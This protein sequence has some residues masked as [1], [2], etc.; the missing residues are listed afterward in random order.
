[1]EINTKNTANYKQLTINT[2]TAS[3]NKNDSY[4]KRTVRT[5]HF[6]DKLYWITYSTSFGSDTNSAVDIITSH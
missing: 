4:R 1:V 6:V 2:T 5:V 3:F